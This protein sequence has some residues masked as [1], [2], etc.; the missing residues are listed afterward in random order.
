[1][2]ELYL[3]GEIEDLP[4][5]YGGHVALHAT[6]HQPLN[7]KAKPLESSSTA[8]APVLQ[9]DESEALLRRVDVL[10]DAVEPEGSRI[11][12]VGGRAPVV[13]APRRPALP[14]EVVRVCDQ[15]LRVRKVKDNIPTEL[16]DTG[17]NN[18]GKHP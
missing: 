16:M 8:Q 6:W 3:A 13:Q 10:S 2:I 11:E 17:R 4:P 1:M 9:D 18:E 14:L 12:A 5:S 7:R 15:R